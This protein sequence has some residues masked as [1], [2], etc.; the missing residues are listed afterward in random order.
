MCQFLTLHFKL[1]SH[2]RALKMDFRGLLDL[3]T[4]LSNVATLNESFSA[5]YFNLAFFFYGFIEDVWLDL[6]WDTGYDPQVR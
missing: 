2:S 1:G 4:A 6:T 3:F 5:F